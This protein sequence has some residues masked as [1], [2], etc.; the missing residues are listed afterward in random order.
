MKLKATFYYTG[1]GDGPTFREVEVVGIH[2]P[3]KAGMPYLKY[4]GDNRKLTVYGYEIAADLLP[5]FK[6]Y[7]VE[8]CLGLTIK[9]E[10]GT[11]SVAPLETSIAEVLEGLMNRARQ[12]G[13]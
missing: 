5:Q 1:S 2:K 7:H 12:E 10:A 6:S 11:G 4:Y 13:V 9:L 8:K 3:R